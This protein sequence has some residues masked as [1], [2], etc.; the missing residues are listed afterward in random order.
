MQAI[1]RERLLWLDESDQSLENRLRHLPSGQGPQIVWF[2]ALLL[3]EPDRHLL[4]VNVHFTRLPLQLA[5][6]IGQ[7]VEGPQRLGRMI[8]QHSIS[9]R[10]T[11]N[12]LPKRASLL[13]C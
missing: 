10:V 12:T 2:G 6:N 4:V 3:V 9:H 1:L 5:W 7:I 13:V 11:C 8:L